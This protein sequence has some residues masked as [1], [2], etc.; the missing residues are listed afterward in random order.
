M[1]ELI[2]TMTL[3]YP[4]SNISIQ[5]T[6]LGYYETISQ[7]EYARKHIDIRYNTSLECVKIGK[8]KI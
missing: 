2:L 5:K 8:K 4:G 3:M 7:C 6:V 1:Y